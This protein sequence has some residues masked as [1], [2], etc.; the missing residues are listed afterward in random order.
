MS[1]QTRTAT[2]AIRLEAV[3]LDRAPKVFA[4]CRFD[5]D[6]DELPDAD[7]TVDTGE[8]VDDVVGWAFAMPDGKVLIV[9]SD[10]SRDGMTWCNDIESASRF[11]A[12]LIGADLLAVA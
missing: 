10:G 5:D 7:E 9:H 4:L 8:A 2:T 1:D 12:P 3:L 6:Y 11:W